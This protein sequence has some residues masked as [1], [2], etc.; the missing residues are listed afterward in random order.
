MN[1]ASSPSPQLN[2]TQK[3]PSARARSLTVSVLPVPAGPAGAPP[4]DSASA[5][6]SASR[7]RSVTGV[8]TSRGGAP[9]N[10]QP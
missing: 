5:L 4:S 1:L 7:A 8:A 10:S 2:T 6:V 3:R 9:K